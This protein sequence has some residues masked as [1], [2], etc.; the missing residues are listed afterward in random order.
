MCTPNG[1]DEFIR[2]LERDRQNFI[3]GFVCNREAYQSHSDVKTAFGKLF[4]NKK[5]LKRY[6]KPDEIESAEYM[7]LA[8]ENAWSRKTEAES[9]HATYKEIDLDEGEGYGQPK[10]VAYRDI[11]GLANKAERLADKARRTEDPSRPLAEAISTLSLMAAY[12]N[13]NLLSVSRNLAQRTANISRSL[14]S[15]A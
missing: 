3:W 14:L 12:T 7:R 15:P 4:D 10:R 5:A 2:W 13:E 8:K 1:R 6:L 11:H 9:V